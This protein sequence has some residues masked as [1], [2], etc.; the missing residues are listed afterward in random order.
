MVSIERMIHQNLYFLE[1]DQP[2][3][4]YLVLLALVGQGVPWWRIL[5]P[6]LASY[7]WKWTMEHGLKKAKGLAN[8]KSDSPF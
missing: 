7:H 2:L 3:M 1:F 5:T 6:R 8:R 4:I